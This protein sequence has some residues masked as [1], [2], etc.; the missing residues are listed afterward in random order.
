MR[1]ALVR[2]RYNPFG[3]AER[4]IERTLPALERAGVELTLIARRADGWGAR[5]FLEVNPFYLGNVWR[6]ASFA[7]ATREAWEAGNFD[8]VQSHERIPGCDIY[9]AG[10][11]VHAEWLEIRRAA[12]ERLECLG[13][14]L[15]P[16]HRY[17]C[18]AE[19]RM[20]AHPR[21]RAVICNS[22]MVREEIRQRFGLP[23]QRLH[24]IYNGVDLEHFHPR[25]RATLRAPARAKLG[26][27]AGE[28]LF[29][30]VGS[31]F[32]RKGLDA[33]I[34]ALAGC[35]DAPYRLAVAGRDREAARFAAL[36]AARGLGDRVQ[37]L[38]GRDDVRPLYAAADCFILP[39][40]YDPYPNTFLEALAMGLPAIVGRR[41]GAAEIVRHGENGWLC[42]PDNVAGL[43]QLMHTAAG[44]VADA[45]TGSAAAAAARS[46]AENYGIDDMA[47]KLAALYV[48]LAASTP[49]TA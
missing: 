4:F 18:A 47:G 39:T 40:R 37:L 19:R 20:F 33:A 45:G 3:G 49:R 14:A 10:D 6:D 29:L 28:T 32:A 38:G 35:G 34:A 1:V 36:A 17:V 44:A 11:G 25:H 15:N 43:A 30:F 22:N 9:R 27:A 2:Q 46:T 5:R 42:E 8:L 21:L 16:Y 13:I 7:R 41:S 31:G 23:S 12:A 24:V 26:V 48:T